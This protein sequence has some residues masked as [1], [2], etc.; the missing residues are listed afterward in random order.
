MKVELGTVAFFDSRVEKRYGFIQ[1]DE[2][3]PDVFFHINNGKVPEAKVEDVVFVTPLKCSLPPVV[4]DRIAFVRSNGSKGRAKACPWAYESAFLSA[5]FMA[6]L[7]AHEYHLRLEARTTDEGEVIEDRLRR[8]AEA[9][10][11]EL[12]W[13][14]TVQRSTDTDDDPKVE[15]CTGCDQPMRD[16]ECDPD[17]ERNAD[18]YE[19]AGLVGLEEPDTGSSF[20]TPFTDHASGDKED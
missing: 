5:E 15:L 10:K 1:S 8:E 7:N 18:L 4:G 20:D 16:C 17:E 2:G 13:R 9:L 11:A 6:S 19:R 14:D 3:G 12:D